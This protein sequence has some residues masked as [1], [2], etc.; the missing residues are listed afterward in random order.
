MTPFIECEYPV[1]KDKQVYKY[2]DMYKVMIAD[3]LYNMIVFALHFA[4]VLLQF[5]LKAVSDDA[6]MIYIYIYINMS[7]CL[8]C[9]CVRD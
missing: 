5:T 3:R 2:N 7:F 9:P 6:F 1:Q 8:I 4:I